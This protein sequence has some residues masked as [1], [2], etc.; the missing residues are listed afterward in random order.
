ML[1]SFYHLTYNKFVYELSE[2]REAALLCQRVGVVSIFVHDTVSL[3]SPG[4]P[5]ESG[6]QLLQAVLS[7]EVEQ[8]GKLLVTLICTKT[9]KEKT[10][11]TIHTTAC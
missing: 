9:H 10:G 4:T 11:R 5:E 7:S 2:I 1:H 6:G 8:C 3:Q